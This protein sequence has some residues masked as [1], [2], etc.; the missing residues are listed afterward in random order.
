MHLKKALI[1]A[2][3]LILV[4]ELLCFILAPA[5]QTDLD[6]ALGS[7]E[8][9]PYMLTAMTLSFIAFFTLLTSLVLLILRGDLKNHALAMA[10]LFVAFVFPIVGYMVA[11]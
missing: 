5:A 10:L 6:A 7:L 2:S 1:I 3:S 4:V 9:V 11:Y 8:Y